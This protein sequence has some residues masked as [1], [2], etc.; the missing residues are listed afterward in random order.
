MDR[1][2][3]KRVAIAEKAARDGGAV[4]RNWFREEL[5]VDT[6]SGKTDVVTRADRE[7]Q[8]RIIEVI[9]EAYPDEPIVGEEE[10]AMKTVPHSGPAWVADPI[11]G[12]NNFVRKMPI[13][14]TSVAA[15]R[16]GEPVAAC[17]YLPMMGD[18]YS[19]DSRGARRNGD[20]IS[21]NDRE[22][23]ERCTVVPTLWW[24]FDARDEYAAATKA[25]V[26]RF[27]DLRRLGSIQVCLAM[28]AEGSLEG[29]LSNIWPNPWDT[30]AGVYL[31]RQAGGTV[32]DIHGDPWTHASQGIVASNGRVH[33]SVLEA[34]QD[35]VG[36]ISNLDA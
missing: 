3:S 5:P 2:V 9:T 22:D 21:V 14:T 34:T 25:I 15:V 32:T 12:T 11:D 30:I 4:A 26:E 36:G 27:G 13:W 24:E 19:A 31:V 1:S 20:P 23:P 29:V 8:D 17:N 33:Q 35:V 10:D 7:A 18:T 6:K 16:D 28:L